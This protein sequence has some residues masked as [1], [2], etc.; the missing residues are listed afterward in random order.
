MTT[1]AM[2]PKWTEQGILEPK[3]SP[4]CLDS[5]KKAFRDMRGEFRSF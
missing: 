4:R 5:A 1:C 3:D 2:L